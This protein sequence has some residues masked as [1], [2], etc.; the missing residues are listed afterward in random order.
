[1]DHLVDDPEQYP[2]IKSVG[3]NSGGVI[4]T[5]QI[6][7]IYGIEELGVVALRDGSRDSQALPRAFQPTMNKNVSSSAQPRAIGAEK[8]HLFLVAPSRTLYVI[9]LTVLCLHFNDG[10]VTPTLCSIICCQNRWMDVS[11]SMY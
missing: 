6:I 7:P 3:S 11:F 5:V 9:R 2:K 1:M 4:S 10:F 8:T